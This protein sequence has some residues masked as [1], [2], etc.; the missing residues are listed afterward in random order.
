MGEKHVIDGVPYPV[1]HA[2]KK[3]GDNLRTARLRR[4]LTIEEVAEKIGAGPR[5]VRAAESGK[6]STGMAHAG[7]ANDL[8]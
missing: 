2:I 1:E 4:K 3:V 6:P 8:A 5:A 7:S